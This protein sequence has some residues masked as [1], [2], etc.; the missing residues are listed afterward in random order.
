MRNI[1]KFLGIMIL[2]TIIGLSMTACSDPSPLDTTL[3]VVNNYA[4]PITRV[5]VELLLDSFI[6]L[7]RGSLNITSPNSQAFSFSIQ[8]PNQHSNVTSVMS[9]GEITLY[10]S[11]LSGGFALLNSVGLKTGEITTVIL[12][13]DGTVEIVSQPLWY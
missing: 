12:L 4:N 5:K 8:S 1:F 6:V 3:V 11:G 10:A 2:L 7:D 9:A 13:S